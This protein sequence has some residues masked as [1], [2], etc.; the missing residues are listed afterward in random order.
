MY[1]N[2]IIAYACERR[3]RGASSLRAEG[4]EALNVLILL[5]GGLSEEEGGC[6]GSLAA[7][8]V[9]PDLFEF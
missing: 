6:P 2:G 9:E 1:V 7:S 5:Q 4:W 8:T 3:Y